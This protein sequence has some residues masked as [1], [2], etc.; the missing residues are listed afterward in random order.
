MFQPKFPMVL[1]VIGSY[2]S[3]MDDG[4]GRMS[5]GKKL[6]VFWSWA[7]Q[8]KREELLIKLGDVVL[9]LGQMFYKFWRA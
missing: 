4:V 2:G 6:D 8:G 5:K 1:Y 7:K 9:V 3:I